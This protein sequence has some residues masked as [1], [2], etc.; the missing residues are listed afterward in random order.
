MAGNRLRISSFFFVVAVVAAA[1]VAGYFIGRSA[2][3]THPAAP[4][5][6]WRAIPS[7]P[8]VGRIYEATV[9]TGRELIVAGGLSHG[10]PVDDGAAYDPATGTWRRI[11]KPPSDL[12][13]A[14]VW[15]GT[16]MITWTGNGVD[17]PVVGAV[18]N[19]RTDMWR[20]L[21]AGPLGP[22]EGNAVVW[23]G[24]ELLV[25]GGHRG[26][27]AAAP[28]A[29][30]VDPATGIWRILHGLDRLP[31]FG[32]PQGAVWDGREV[33][34]AGNVSLC[35]EKGSACGRTRASVIAY[36][37]ATDAAHE[38]SQLAPSSQY[39]S[40]AAASLR[41]I[42][43]TGTRV[44]FTTYTPGVFRLL[45]YTPASAYW[46][47]GDRAPCTLQHDTDTQMVWAGDRFVAGCSTGGVQVYDPDTRQW[48]TLET[49]ASP[50]TSR[51]SSAIAWTGK[52]LIVWSGSEFRPNGPTPA[53]GA[54]LTLPR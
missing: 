5:V 51:S 38:L 12:G 35:P 49:G 13:G 8:I 37:P 26:D 1:G 22:R 34:L 46:E 48:R 14:A 41:P 16:E 15:T 36:E 2:T 25:I 50:F 43:W 24:K 19:P 52:E 40:D 45:R 44:V 29:A 33:I 27:G 32:G 18:Y 20:R 17:G 3:T 9:W 23:T 21:P 54:I 30:A 53:D 6:R 11:A 42:A 7:A 39:G 31:F 4:R 47:L 10:R 28:V